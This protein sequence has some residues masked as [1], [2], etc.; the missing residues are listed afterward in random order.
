MNNFNIKVKNALDAGIIIGDGHSLYAPEFYEPFFTADELFE[1][2]L[3]QTHK[4]DGS[5]KGSIYDDNGAIIDEV[6]GVYNLNFLYWVS[7]QLGIEE[8]P[9]ANGRGSQAQELVRFIINKLEV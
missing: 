3:I 8:T 4:S 5:H 2:R 1:A 9:R 6:Q 7:G